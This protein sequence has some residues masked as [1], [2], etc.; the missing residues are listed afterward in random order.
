MALQARCPEEPKIRVRMQGVG[1]LGA[2]P[3]PTLT[4]VGTAKMAWGGSHDPS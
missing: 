3:E 1:C 2:I 4:M